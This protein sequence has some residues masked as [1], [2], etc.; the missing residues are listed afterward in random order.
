MTIGIACWG[1][2][3]VAGAMAAVLGAELLGR[4]DIGGFAVLSVLDADLQFQHVSVQRGGVSELDFPTSWHAARYAA[5]ISSGPDR[6]VPLVQFLPGQSQIGLVT[7]HRLPSLIG[8]DGVAVNQAVL[9]RLVKGMAPQQAI[10]EVLASESEKDVGLI[11][12]DLEGR[13]GFAN[14][15][16]VLRRPDI[17]T[18]HYSGGKHGFAILHNSIFS[19]QPSTQLLAD[20]LAELANG[21]L[22]GQQHGHGMLRFERVITLTLSDA[23]R[24]HI[25]E[26]GMIIAI[27]TAN[28]ALMIGENPARTVIYG[29][30]PVYLNG[31]Q[32]GMAACELHARLDNGVAHPLQRLANRRAIIRYHE[33]RETA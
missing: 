33:S 12:L 14:T 6:P 1:E 26:D 22:S 21:T 13:I 7:G 8:Q 5:I 25:D 9:N 24:I 30:P 18:A 15:A 31:K 16:R 27:D 2:H 29:A 10:D 11:A 17:G 32:V 3:A 20:S 28:P 4:G 23:D 19:N